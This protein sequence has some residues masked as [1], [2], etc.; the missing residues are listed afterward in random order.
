M[1]NTV[2][3]QIDCHQ[4][5]CQNEANC[6]IFENHQKNSKLDCHQKNCQKIFAPEYA[7]KNIRFG[8]NIFKESHKGINRC[9]KKPHWSIAINIREIRK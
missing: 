2:V 6:L 4:V 9:K 3:G 5:N 8:E 7:A 1:H